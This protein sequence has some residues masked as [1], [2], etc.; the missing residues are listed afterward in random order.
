L[1]TAA[2]LAADSYVD[3]DLA[4]TYDLVTARACQGER[5]APRRPRPPS[6]RL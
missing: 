6:P 4:A 2:A 5:F 3:A 1:V